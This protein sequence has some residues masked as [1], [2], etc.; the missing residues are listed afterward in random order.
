MD[1]NDWDGWKML[2]DNGDKVGCGFVT[3]VERLATGID[4]G[5]A[6]SILVKVNKFTLT[7][8]IN[9]VMAASWE[10]IRHNVI[11]GETKTT[12]LLS[13]VAIE[14]WSNQ[15]L[16]L[17]HVPIIQNKVLDKIFLHF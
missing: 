9:T 12:Q 5:I 7:E 6:N 11:D 16:V 10:S 14:L 3:N 15:D 17:E 8:T 4:R 2:T 1:E 13:S